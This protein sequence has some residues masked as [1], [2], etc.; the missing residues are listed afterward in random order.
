VSVIAMLFCTKKPP[1][2]TGK[3]WVTYA[4]HFCTKKALFDQRLSF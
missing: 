2:L 1:V 3:S 4:R